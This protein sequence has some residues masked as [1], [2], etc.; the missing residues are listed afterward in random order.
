[1]GCHQDDR[2]RSKG[3]SIDSFATAV[4]FLTHAHSDHYRGL[5]AAY[6]G[7]IYC[8]LLTHQLLVDAVPALGGLAFTHIETGQESIRVAGVDVCAID[9]HHCAGSCMYRFCVDGYTCLYTG[10]FRFE[11]TVDLRGPVDMLYF[12]DT[13]AG[14][15]RLPTLAETRAV[16]AETLR[17]DRLRDPTGQVYIHAS[18][19]G[20]ETVLPRELRFAVSHASLPGHRVTQLR[21]LLKDQVD[22]ASPY[23]L[24]DRTPGAS[25]ARVGDGCPWVIPTCTHFLCVYGQS[26]LATTHRDALDT[27]V[28]FATHPDKR[29]IQRLR[30]ACTPTSVR[31]CGYRVAPA[32]TAP[33]WS[34]YRARLAR[35]PSGRASSP[36]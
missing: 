22:D 19:L 33:R 25:R 35:G 30:D 7:A 34:A 4:V 21:R 32:C 8:T 36:T 15:D 17:R 24:A 23:I 26:R 5:T 29:E 2:L 16:I 31:S 27:Y 3:I 18:I 12:D 28:L 13:F 10:D 14:L 9:A 20:V 1:M 11:D 6:T